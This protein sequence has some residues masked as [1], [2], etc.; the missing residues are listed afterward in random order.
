MRTVSTVDIL[1]IVGVA[2]IVLAAVSL[3]LSAFTRGVKRIAV[4]FS[5]A[6]GVLAIGSWVAVGLR[7]ATDRAIAA[8]STSV[9]FVASLG[10]IA[11]TAGLE[12]GRRIERELERGRL[13]LRSLID[14]E[15]RQRVG[16]LDRLL[17]RARADSSSQLAEQERGLTESRRHA[18]AEAEKSFHEKLAEMIS[19]A[20]R[21]IEEKIASWRRDL[22]RSE[23]TLG[24]EVGDLIRQSERLIQ[25][26]RARIKADGDRIESE[27][28]EHRASINRLREEMAESIEQALAAN[29]DELEKFANERRRAIQEIVERLGRREREVLERVEREEAEAQRRIQAGVAEIERRQLE[30]LERYM[31]RSVSS[32]SDDHTRQ[33]DD[34]MRGAREEAARRLNRELERAIEH[35]SRQAQTK[36][37]DRMRLLGDDSQ[38]RLETRFDSVLDELRERA[39]LSWNALEKRVADLEL[40]LRARLETIGSESESA[41][42]AIESR[43]Q[44]LHRHLEDLRGDS[45]ERWREAPQD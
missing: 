30:Q 28:E 37:D 21:D 12:R 17:A 18:I 31:E 16:E 13:Q 2:A 36:L 39:N 44:Q 10:A 29:Q 32:V 24:R 22:G 41:R 38:R 15:T 23:D 8:A 33:F 45:N 35:Y 9:A 4:A 19:E 42:S 7:P 11:L 25:E 27:S 34:A 1:Q 3:A 20:Q 5:T 43:F 6:I 14:D 26:M 40:E